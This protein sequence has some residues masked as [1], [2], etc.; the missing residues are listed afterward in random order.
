MRRG[1]DS[2]RVIHAGVIERRRVRRRRK[3]EASNGRGGV[4]HL[5]DAVA[6][7]GA[8]RRGVGSAVPIQYS[9]LVMN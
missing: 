9:M 6:A 3:R 7:G 5:G 8:N 2:V 4:R 1:L